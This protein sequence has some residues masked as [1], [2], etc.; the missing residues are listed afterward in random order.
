MTRMGP[1]P[2]S[3]GRPSRGRIYNEWPESARSSRSAN[4]EN[5]DSKGYIVGR[6]ARW[7]EWSGVVAASIGFVAALIFLG[8]SALIPD[9]RLLFLYAG[10]AIFCAWLVRTR[11]TKLKQGAKG[12][13]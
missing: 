2:G 9:W 12:L 4:R 6:I 8:L 10:L 13:R 1:P 11:I 7:I 3:F 5:M